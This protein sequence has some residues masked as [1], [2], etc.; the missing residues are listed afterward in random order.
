MP[1]LLSVPVTV[2]CGCNNYGCGDIR[3]WQLLQDLK[4]L[5]SL[6]DYVFQYDAITFY[7][8]LLDEKRKAA[9][10]KEPPLWIG[11]PAAER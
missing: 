1:L 5:R 7:E 3:R 6:L 2:G 9:A 8:L 10:V 11:T 4:T